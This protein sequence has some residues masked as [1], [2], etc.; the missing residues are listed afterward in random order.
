[1]QGSGPPPANDVWRERV[2]MVR[3]FDGETIGGPLSL[4]DVRDGMAQGR[5]DG[6]VLIAREG[7]TAWRPIED[8][9]DDASDML[10][11]V[12]GVDAPPLGVM[13][14]RPPPPPPAPS[15][16]PPPPLPAV[17]AWFVAVAPGQ[18]VGP[19]TNE[20]VMQ[21]I[22]NGQVPQGGTVCVAGE[23]AWKPIQSIPAFADA[24]GRR[25]TA[26]RSGPVA[27]VA[28]PAEAPEVRISLKIFVLLCVAG[29]LLLALVLV[30]AITL[31]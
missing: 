17:S 27:V 22:A 9:M 19:V 7:S 8:V 10:P 1:M 14:S 11:T 5:L 31:R 29:L 4:V 13:P 23:T 18:V 12:M 15:V 21:A 30:L 25:A 20:Q 28:P 16:R 2:W 26:P 24:F 3:N 6:A